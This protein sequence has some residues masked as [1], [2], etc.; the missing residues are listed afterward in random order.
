M[1]NSNPNSMKLVHYLG[2]LLLF[3]IAKGNVMSMAP[4]NFLDYV[5]SGD[6]SDRSLAMVRALQDNDWVYVPDGTYDFATLPV[7]VP[8]NTRITLAPGAVIRRAAAS[9][10]IFQNVLSTSTAGGYSGNSNIIIE[11]GTIDSRGAYYRSIDADVSAVIL[12]GHCE[13]VLVR[14]MVIKDV[15]GYHAIEFNSVKSGSAVRVKMIGFV[16]TASGSRDHSEALQIDLARSGG[17]VGPGDSTPCRDISVTNCYFGASGTAGTQAWPSGVGSHS[18]A[19]GI[20]HRFIKVTDNVFEGTT[21]YAVK[22]YVWSEAVVSGN[23]FY[24]CNGAVWAR[25]LDIAGDSQASNDLVIQSNTITDSGARGPAIHLQGEATGRIWDSVVS[26]NVIRNSGQQGINVAYSTRV[27]VA[28]NTITGT[29]SHGIKADFTE[30]IS[31]TGNRISNAGVYGITCTDTVETLCSTNR[32]SNIN[33]IGIYFSDGSAALIQ[34]NDIRSCNTGGGS[35]SGIR[36][37]SF[38]RVTLSGNSYRKDTSKSSHAV[39]AISLASSTTNARRFGNMILNQ[40]QTA[41]IDP[42]EPAGVN[43]SPLDSGL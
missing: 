12:F 1:E 17:A 10:N 28:E 33:G 23:T 13:N 43:K 31:L 20:R 35:S 6:G 25:T 39:Y 27:I 14:D 3:L 42:G 9:N 36:V 29:T 22:P 5:L 2:Y 8:A 15:Y 24:G 30:D 21:H 38:D 4:A 34:N 37:K 16:D 41:D 7:F 32:I 26:G 19:L 11:G 40:G 18:G